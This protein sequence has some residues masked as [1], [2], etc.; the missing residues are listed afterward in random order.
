M[1]SSDNYLL[2]VLEALD[3]LGLPNDTLVIRT[4]DPGEM[5]LAHGGLRQKNFVFY[6]EAIRVP[7]VYS[8]PQ[9]YPAPRTS[10]ALVSHVDFL[11]TIA[12]LFRA[13]GSAVGAWQGVDY[14]HLILDPSAPPVQDY[15]VFTCDDYQSGAGTSSLSKP[16]EPYREHP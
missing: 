13:P 9:L 6:E 7:L 5:G 3:D 1:K 2:Q 12:S 14:S 4:A 11:P 16:P 8:N 10:S 15:I